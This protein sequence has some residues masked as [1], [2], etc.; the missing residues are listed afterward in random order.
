MK[1]VVE[2]EIDMP[3]QEVAEQYADPHNNPKWMH[4]LQRYEPIGSDQGMPG[5]TYRLVPKEGDMIFLATVSER[6]LPHQL[7]VNFEAATVD[8]TM[9]ATMIPLSPTRT[10]LIS[11]EEFTFKDPEN[12]SV[13]SSVKEAIKA[14]HRRHIEDF[15][16][17]MEDR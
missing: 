8:M 1:S 12:G 4:D 13:A 2:V 14:V 7:R 11:E 16:H 17:F 6:N 3:L 10:K 5:S 9:T 15:K